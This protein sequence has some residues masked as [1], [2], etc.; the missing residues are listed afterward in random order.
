MLS[1]HPQGVFLGATEKDA[2]SISQRHSLFCDLIRQA[3]RGCF[4]YATDVA[5]AYCQLPL[6][7]SDG[8]L[9][10]FCFEGRL[11]VD[12]SLPFCL[13]W[14]ASHCQ[15]ATNIIS[16]ELRRQ[17]VTLLNYIDNFGGVAP[18]RS[19]AE[20]LFAQLQGLL[21]KLGLQEARHKSP[22]H[23]PSQNMVW[24]GFRFDMVAMTVTLPPEKLAEIMDLVSS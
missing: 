1:D 20:S 12:V 5:R 2:P 11:F 13:R 9:I 15:D 18:S 23:L 21:A 4:L 7:P 8:L 22:P 3:G 14:A 16:R 24:L 10:C 19:T 17:G 6:D